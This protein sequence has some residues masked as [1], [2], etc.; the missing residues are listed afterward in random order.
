VA[1][2]AALRHQLIDAAD[3]LASRRFFDAVAEI[4][5]AASLS[6]TTDLRWCN[7][8]AHVYDATPTGTRR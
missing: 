6:T 2:N 1:E 5:D 3:P 8:R 7:W 4:R